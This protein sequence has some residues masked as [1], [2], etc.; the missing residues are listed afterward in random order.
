MK[1]KIIQIS[2]I[3]GLLFSIQASA[4]SIKNI[5]LSGLNVI[6]NSTVLTYL[7]VKAGDEIVS[8]TSDQIIK[9]LFA[10][11]FFSDV[12][13]SIE[14]DTVNVALVEN[15]HIK[16][17]DVLNYSDS[18]LNSGAV[19]STLNAFALESGDIYNKRGLFGVITALKAMYIAEGFYNI[20][21]EQ[22]I[23]LDSQNRIGIELVINEG[24]RAKVGSM[25]ISGSVAYSEE[26]LLDLFDIGV[27]DN[28]IVNFFTDKD[29]YNDESLNKGL[30]KLRNLYSNNGYLDSSVTSNT[31]LSEDKETINIEIHITEGAQ[32]ILGNLTFSGNLGNQTADD[33][34]ALF[35][36]DSGSIFN[37][38]QARNGIQKITH[39][40]ANQGYA[41]VDVGSI[42]EKD[43]ESNSMHL[44]IGIT[45]NKKFYINRITIT[46]NTRTQDG[47]IRR[48]IGLSEGSLY[49]GSVIGESLNRLRRLGYFSSILLQTNR[50]ENTPDKIDLNFVVQETMTGALSGGI[51]HSNNF[52]VSFNAGIRERN[53]LGSGNMLNA[54][55]QYSETFKKLSFY[56][57]DPYYNSENHSV[58]YGVFVSSIDDNQV[59]QDSYQVNSKGFSFGYGVPLTK[60]TRLNAKL[61]YSNN[62]ITCGS[63]FA[64]AEYEATQCAYDNRNEI[65]LNLNWSENTLNHYMY[66]TEGTINTFNIDLGLPLG[67]YQYI[68]IDANHR[69]YKSLK[70]NLT[71]KLT[72]GLG[73]ATGYGSESLPFYKRYF[74]GGSGS[75]RGFK[76]KTLGP[77]YP[78]GNPK[79][80]EFSILASANVISPITFIDDSENMRMSVFVDV[81]NVYESISLDLGELRMSAGVAFAF[82]SPIGAIGIYMA[83]PILKKSGDVTE[84]FAVSLG[85]GF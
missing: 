70:N 25:T 64:S 39:S 8:D 5:E 27:A 37:W 31:S 51:S 45:L 84:D 2:I 55:L 58:N 71:L 14:N 35:S 10:T 15:P 67:D 50:V 74:G 36:L 22:N 68:K 72:A 29:R 26:N 3:I 30:E 13:V 44:N 24:K 33:L 56:F 6:L 54:E 66:P 73:I 4:T 85:T 78:N 80:G 63:V 46:G 81:G 77:V 23:D 53:F 76:A 47:V 40:Y 49:S 28:F 32:Y 11:G 69:S 18:V 21:I 12:L 62:D 16:Y 41:Y 60:N 1:N 61:Q 43:F 34:R 17:I 57:E 20:E 48:E 83:L 82:M 59:S 52:G 42:T 38:Q 65:K 19:S 75:V 9:T 79:G 7:P